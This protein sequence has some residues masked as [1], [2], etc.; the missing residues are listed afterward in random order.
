MLFSN[1]A[2]LNIGGSSALGLVLLLLF[3]GATSGCQP[4][5]SQMERLGIE[6]LGLMVEANQA[7]YLEPVITTYIQRKLPGVGITSSET[8]SHYL[9]IPLGF[10]YPTLMEKVEFGDL[11]GIRETL[12][13]DYLLAV[14]IREGE[15]PHHT[16]SLTIGTEKSEFRLSQHKIVTL[17]YMI[18]NTSTSETIF[19]GQTTGKSSDIAD[20]KVG[21]SGTKVGIQLSDEK[22]LMKEAVLEA[23][24]N[25]GLF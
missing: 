3:M 12:G 25:T 18:I 10:D 15:S 24:K 14:S 20:L 7:Q 1:Q 4:Q 17:Y 16:T 2:G 23:L 21:T 8:I 22:G 9:G 19:S 6:S 5:P 13:I 11:L